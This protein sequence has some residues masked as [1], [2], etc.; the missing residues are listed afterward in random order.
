[1]TTPDPRRKSGTV[2]ED[3][4]PLPLI[5]PDIIDP[6]ARIER[7]IPEIVENPNCLGSN[8]SNSSDI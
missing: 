7:Q 5:T 3:G 6:I 4:R 1:M 8:V 2:F